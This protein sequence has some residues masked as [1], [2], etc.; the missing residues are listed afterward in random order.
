[1]LARA[2]ATSG[3]YDLAMAAF[4]QAANLADSDDPATAVEVLLD[5]AFCTMLSAARSA[6]G[7]ISTC[8]CAR[9]RA[10]HPGR[11][12]RGQD[13]GLRRGGPRRSGCWPTP[14]AARLAS[15]PGRAGT[16]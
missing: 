8:R 11:P 13:P 12:G 3:Q 16:V 6:T 15:R 1:M 4:E 14:R 10:S 7:F 2:L 5:A 9:G